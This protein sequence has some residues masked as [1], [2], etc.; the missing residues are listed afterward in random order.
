MRVAFFPDSSQSIQG[1]QH[2]DEKMSERKFSKKYWDELTHK[3]GLSLEIPADEDDDESNSEDE[4][5]E[6]ESRSNMDVALNEENEYESEGEENSK[7][8]EDEEMADDSQAVGY[9][10]NAGDNF[11]W[12]NW[13]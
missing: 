11:D 6:S 10:S 8:D 2:P 5:I 12:E 7:L 1:I 3:Y 13:Q 9:F 4:D